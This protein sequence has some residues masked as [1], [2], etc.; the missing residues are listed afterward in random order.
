M[1]YD[2]KSLHVPRVWGRALRTL[3]SLLENGYTNQ[4][5]KKQLFK[6]GGL[7]RLNDIY[8]DNPPVNMP[9]HEATAERDPGKIE[10]AEKA[11]SRHHPNYSHSDF[12]Y[13]SY[14]HYAEAYRQQQAS[15]VQIAER[16]IDALD[17][18][19][20]TI[21]AVINFNEQYIRLQAEESAQR[22]KAG[23]PRSDLEGVP[24]AVKDEIDTVPYTTS[25]G[26]QIY[27]LDGSAKD[28]ATVVA[29]LK[30]AGALIIGKANMH[31][32]GIGVTGANPHFGVC[33]N[34]YDP[35]FHTGGSSSGSAAAV[36]AGLCPIAIAAD[37]GGSVRIPAAMCGQVGL[38]ATWSRI[39]EMGAAPL[40]W[41][42]AHIGPIGCTVDDVALS[43]K[44][45]AGADPHD[46]WTLKQPTPHLIDYLNDKLDGLRL[47]IYTEWFSHA[48]KDI[49]DCCDNA[50]DILVKHGAVRK[51]VVINGLENQ[52][53][54][55][56]VTIGSEMLTAVEREFAKGTDKFALDTR[57]NLALASS[58]SSKDYIKAQRL[59][60]QAIEEYA[61]VF[62]QADVILTPCTG[63]VAPEINVKA[64]PDGESDLA[65]L[66]EI[67]RF[68]TPANLTG[69]PAITVPVGYSS[70]GLPIG[71][72]IMG[73]AWEEHVLLRLARI[74]EKHI[75]KV[76]P[77]VFYHL[78]DR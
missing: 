76:K 75:S 8:I 53:L 57:I 45:M 54:A 28:D 35:G 73:R 39:S 34:P 52:R 25:V 12:Q 1:S 11:F 42:V 38:K 64:L 5:V 37:G 44:L 33:R 63:V 32:I 19:Q 2:L 13:P 49:V 24:V 50:I 46:P 60:A 10:A 65:T 47:G 26:T 69:L 70:T 41:S 71:L 23:K 55:H 4:I 61:K 72:Q 74:V 7:S 31:E 66:T 58:F 48:S 14:R 20:S 56:V 18:Q 21:N 62:E 59:R 43:Y 27:G 78:L 36:A 3:V 29:R 15:P 67:M 77:R 40:C 9:Q 51:S 16:I 30:A 6:E 22:I 68:V 17:A